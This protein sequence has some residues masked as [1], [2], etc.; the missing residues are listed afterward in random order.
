MYSSFKKLQSKRNSENTCHI[1]FKTVR[2]P[3]LTKT[4]HIK[5][6]SFSTYAKFSEKLTFLT[7]S[8]AHVCVRIRGSEMLVFRKTLPTY[9]MNDPLYFNANILMILTL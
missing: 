8:Y 4:Y 6:Y 9:Y 7:P 2:S 3:V 1:A 5:G